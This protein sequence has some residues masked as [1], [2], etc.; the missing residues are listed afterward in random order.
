MLCSWFIHALRIRACQHAPFGGIHTFVRHKVKMPS[1]KSFFRVL[2][3]RAG[4][5][6]V[7]SIAV[8]ERRSEPELS[9]EFI[10]AVQ[11]EIDSKVGEGVSFKPVTPAGW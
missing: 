3:R 2:A 4:A 1:K 6:E 9:K 8:L 5:T 10:E 11:R 7:A